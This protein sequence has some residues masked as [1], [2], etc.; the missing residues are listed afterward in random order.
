MCPV[1]QTV[2]RLPVNAVELTKCVGR[3][4]CP[5]T[6]STGELPLPQQAGDGKLLN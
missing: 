5:V 1:A 4:A 6:Q 3:E 2:G